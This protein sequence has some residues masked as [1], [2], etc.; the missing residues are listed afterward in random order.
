MKHSDMRGAGTQE[1]RLR[2]ELLLICAAALL[3]FAGCANQSSLSLE[4]KPLSG[5]VQMTQVQAAYLG[6]GNAGSGTLRYHGSTYPFSVGG[7][8]VGGIGISKIEAK[9][10]V[11]GLQRVGDFAGAYA[12]ARYG[13]ALG[14]TSAGEL[15]LQNRKGVVMH[16]KAKREGLMLSLGGDA[17]VVEMNQ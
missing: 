5:Y 2:R 15:W 11:Y 7:L 13:F 8:G 6:S 4:G 17:V 3:S 14:T 16:L 9:G 10:E 12:Q 1:L